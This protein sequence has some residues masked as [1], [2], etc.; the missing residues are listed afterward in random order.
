MNT[1]DKPNESLLNFPCSFPIKA[2]GIN[3]EE[4]E[5]AVLSIIKKHSPELEE[6]AIKT[7][8]S[9]GGKYLAITVTIDAQSQAQL[10][11]IYTELSSHEL[12]TMAL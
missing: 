8:S 6:S 12:V 10:D 11:H 1:N 2:M 9:K 5:I 3:S 7:R 4:F